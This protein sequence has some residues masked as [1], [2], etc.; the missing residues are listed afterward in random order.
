[1]LRALSTPC[2][3]F[4]IVKPHQALD[5]FPSKTFQ[6][7]VM[8]SLLNL[9]CVI[10]CTFISDFQLHVMDSGLE[11]ITQCSRPWSFQLHVMD[12][13]DNDI[14][15]LPYDPSFLSTPCYGF[16]IAYTKERFYELLTHHF[17]LHVMD[18]MLWIHRVLLQVPRDGRELSTP[19]YGFSFEELCWELA[20]RKS[21]S[22][23]CYGFWAGLSPSRCSLALAPFNSMLWIQEALRG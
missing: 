2:Y 18:S 1:M 9:S 16:G 15:S 11:L 13:N 14:F 19:C 20:K 12:S 5:Y 3:G 7:H 8:D 17:Q 10:R 22:T 6:L 23:P 21:L 4:L